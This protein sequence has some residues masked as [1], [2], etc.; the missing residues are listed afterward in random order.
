MPQDIGTP[1][2]A[3]P[4]NPLFYGDTGM[5]D[6]SGMQATETGGS[7]GGAGLLGGLFGIGTGIYNLFKAGSI[8]P[9]FVPYQIPDEIKSELALSEGQ[10]NAEMPGTAQYTQNIQQ[11]QG[12]AIGEAERAGGGASNILAS[13]GSIQGQ[14][15]QAYNQLQVAQAQDYQRRLAN[16]Q[17]SQNTMAAYKDKQYEINEYEP[18]I[19]DL[20]R[21]YDLQG[22]GFGNI[23]Q[24]LGSLSGGMLSGGSGGSGGGSSA[25]GFA[26]ILGMLL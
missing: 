26:K 10:L 12:S 3:L 18:Y 21:K 20:Q 5:P 17:Q 22:A 7:G 23:A 1:G 19:R 11:S 25:G 16:L 14:S 13:L 2:L 9:K 15:N 4:T 8:H 6:M 24:G